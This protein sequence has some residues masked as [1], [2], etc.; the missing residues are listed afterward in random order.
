MIADA[1]ADADVDMIADVDVIADVDAD[2]RTYISSGLLQV[3]WR[4]GRERRHDWD[5]QCVHYTG[6]A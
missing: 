6:G 2:A 4:F 3:S 5:A 1:D